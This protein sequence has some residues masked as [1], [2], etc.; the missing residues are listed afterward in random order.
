MW[1]A[2]HQVAA[3]WPPYCEKKTPP[4]SLFLAP[5]SH[6]SRKKKRDTLGLESTKCVY[7]FFSAILYDN[8]NTSKMQRAFLLFQKWVRR[9]RCLN[10]G[11]PRHILS[12]S[13]IY[14]WF[15][16]IIN[17]KMVDLARTLRG[18]QQTTWFIKFPKN[19]IGSEYI[20]RERE[21]KRN[22]WETVFEWRQ[23]CQ[24][25]N[26]ETSNVREAQGKRK[27]CGFPCQVFLLHVNQKWQSWTTFH[28]F[29]FLFFFFNLHVLVYS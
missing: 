11:N 26:W 1:T 7:L 27:R 12:S 5:F 3:W 2:R 25:P 19:K 13:R 9:R 4:A 6:W 8:N 28:M 22:P 21:R 29:C 15:E 16:K 17:A 14:F 20:T 18:F 10:K 23:T 24:V